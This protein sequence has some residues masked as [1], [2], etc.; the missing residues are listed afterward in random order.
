MYELRRDDLHSFHDKPLARLN[1][2]LAQR[3]NRAHE[4]V[5]YQARC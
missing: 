4:V 1:T 3:G 2:G 5:C